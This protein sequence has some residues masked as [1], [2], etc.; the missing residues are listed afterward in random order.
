[1]QMIAIKNLKPHP[2]NDEF[3]DDIDGQK[4]KD[5]IESVKRRSIVEPIVVTQDLVIVS[6]H[7]RVRACKEL[8]IVEIPC[9]VTHYEDVNEKGFAKEDMILE[10]LIC[11]NIM[12]RGVGNVNPVKMAKCIIELERIYGIQK[13]S[14]QHNVGS[15][16]QKD[17]ANNIGITDEQLRR[18]KKLAELIPE[19]QNL[20]EKDEL[21]STVAYSIL[22]KL[23]EEEQFKVLNELKIKNIE[24]PTQK[25]TEIL[26]QKIR[27]RE[28]KIKELSE[29]N[30]FMKKQVSERDELQN[31]IKEIQKSKRELE[32]K[33]VEVKQSQKE[34]I[35][36]DKEIESKETLQKIKE[37]EEKKKQIENERFEY[38]KKYLNVLDELKDKQNMINQFMGS[39]T[40][41]EL[42]SSASEVTSKMMNFLNEMAKYDYLS[43]VFNEIPDATRKEYVRSINGIYKWCKNILSVVKYDDVI[44]INTRIIDIDIQK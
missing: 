31:K 21:K 43:E 8:G 29:Q 13:G 7:Q 33:L 27:E 17:L 19:L 18:Y 28:D 22:A 2:R 16:S 6:G 24:K 1:M 4:W 25:E 40:N 14:N 34:Y 38:S 11:T 42:I 15:T 12:Q 9:R 44:D 36:I 30:D 35:Y 23:P 37:L 20:V 3:F 32:L 39:S 26:L 5:F 10:D 41:F